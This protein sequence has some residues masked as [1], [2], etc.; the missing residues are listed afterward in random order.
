M[1]QAEAVII[2]ASVDHA[3][4]FGLSS[5]GTGTLLKCFKEESDTINLTFYEDHLKMMNGLSRRGQEGI[6]EDCLRG[7]D[8]EGWLST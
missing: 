1:R 8:Q 2:R 5:K 3:K 6:L 7:L 4:N